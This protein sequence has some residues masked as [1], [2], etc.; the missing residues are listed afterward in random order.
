MSWLGKTTLDPESTGR[1]SADDGKADALALVLVWS[2]N[3]GPRLGEVLFP[4]HG[5]VWGRGATSDV[6]EPRVA[7]VRQA[8]GKT[9]PAAELE[10]PFLS[11]RQLRFD[12]PNADT[13]VVEAIGKRQLRVGD[14]EM[15]TT[16]LR[17]GDV[18]AVDGQ[19]AFCCMRRVLTLPEGGS[20]LAPAQFGHADPH[21]IVG[22]GPA[23]WALRAN[24]AFLGKRNAHVL[25]TGASGSGKELVAQ[26]IHRLSSRAR[27]PIVARNAATFPAGLI[28]AELFGNL[29]NY[30]NA[31]MPE[32]PGLIGQA[33]GSTLFLDEIGELPSELQAHLLRV[34][35]GGEYQRL[36]ESKRR[37][38]DIRLVAATNR[39]AEELK[40]D[41]GARL[42][43]RLHLTGLDERPEDVTLLARHLLLRTAARDP[44]LGEAFFEGWNGTHGEPRLSLDLARALVLHAWTTNARE[45]E[46][47]L[48]RSAATSRGKDLELTSDVRK[49]IRIPTPRDA[50]SVT[51]AEIR[52]ALA[53]HGGVKD[54]AWRDLR[55]PSRHALHRLM[56]KMNIPE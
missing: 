14:A 48:L 27:K 31:G 56:K 11:R 49:L 28:D 45:L 54:K 55:L 9:R 33:D 43:L 10:N 3:D 26:A 35:D 8:P 36:G 13:V 39:P 25:V 17:E 51:A 20:D 34:L 22:E 46:A 37:V 30:P 4:K 53:R 7:L 18:F 38:A 15:K 1:T 21:G 6:D 5:A 50:A 16:T 32:R 2:K 47:L 40:E 42:A 23:T 52:D 29:Q 41:L 19:Y 12:V 24:L 44:Q